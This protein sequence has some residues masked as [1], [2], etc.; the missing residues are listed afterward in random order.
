[1]DTQAFYGKRFKLGVLGGGQ[2]GRMLQQPAISLDIDVHF[3]DPA[4]DAPC[5]SLSTGFVVGDFNDYQTV[6][7]FGKDKDM[8]TIE[9][10]NVNV[11]ALE[12]LEKQGVAVCP[13]PKRLQKQFYA[14]NNIPSSN[15]TLI[16]SKAELSASDLPV[17]QKLR[18]GG[19]DGKG[20]QVLMN[21]H[22]LDQAF[23]GPCV[24]EALVDIEKELSVI[25]ARNKSGEVAVYPT[26]EL[27]F[28]PEA[29]L[30]DFLL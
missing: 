24:L 30:V 2:L 29:N 9:I 18:T 22:N 14:N 25:V 20:V 5:S 7:D 13:S 12:D 1:M 27:V 15:F 17:V 19:Y 23:E 21:K 4:P 28:N 16:K 11:K 6:M 8:I 10:E 3:L 26:V